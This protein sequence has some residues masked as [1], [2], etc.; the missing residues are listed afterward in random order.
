MDISTTLTPLGD[1]K[2]PLAFAYDAAR[3]ILTIG[4]HRYS[5][6]LFRLWH[7]PPDGR[8]FRFINGE[9]GELSFEI[10]SYEPQPK[11]ELS[12]G[13]ARRLVEDVS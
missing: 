4:D 8:T 3:D 12:H 6:D 2:A 11:P 1:G 10:V 13:L 7:Q 9:R 5:G